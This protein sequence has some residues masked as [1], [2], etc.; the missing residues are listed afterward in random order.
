MVILKKR[1]LSEVVTTIIIILVVLIALGIIWA[2]IRPLIGKTDT[3]ITYTS[4][5]VA[6][7]LEVKSCVYSNNFIGVSIEKQNTFADLRGIKLILSNGS[8]YEFNLP[9]IP[10][11]IPFLLSSI[12]APPPPLSVDVAGIINVDGNLRTCQPS[13]QSV[14]CN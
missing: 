2:V 4:S 9:A 12:P 13:G 11:N 5:C 6:V 8:I 7:D 3:E 10:G 1:G 14:Q